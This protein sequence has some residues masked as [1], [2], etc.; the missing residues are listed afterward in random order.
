MLALGIDPGTA[1]TGFALVRQ[2][3]SEPELIASGVI[4]TDPDEPLAARLQSIYREVLALARQY[5]P[6]TA[7][8]EEVFFRRNVRT[9]LAVGHARGVVLL[10]LADAGVRVYEYTPSTVKQAVTGYG[11]A[12]KHQM[13]EM[14]RLLLHLPDILRPDDVADAAAIALC[15]L[16]NMRFD[17]ALHQAGSLRET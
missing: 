14:V 1:T 16:Q 15:H 7:A 8:A 6:D 3:D 10:G 5:Q 4:R 2:D 12:D 11:N 9:A 13:Q 17:G